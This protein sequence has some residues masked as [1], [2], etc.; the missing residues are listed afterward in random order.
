MKKLFPTLLLSLFCIHLIAQKNSTEKA[1]P[2]VEEGKTMYRSE[3]ASWYGTDYFLANY[4]DKSNIGGYFSYV[5]GEFS[6]CVFFSKEE[7]PKVIG[8][9]TFDSTYSLKDTEKDL[10]ERSL[11]DLEKNLYEIRRATLQKINSDTTFKQYENTSL[12]LIPMIYKRERKVYVLTGPAKAGVVIFG[13]DYL[14]TFNNEN[15]L[16]ESKPLHKNIL[17]IYY[18]DSAK[19]GEDIK[20]TM[21]THSPETGDFITATDIYTLMLYSK[22]AEWEKHYVVSKKYMSFWDCQNNSLF[23]LPKKAFDKMQRKSKKKKK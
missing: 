10:S 17:P 3:M 8:T 13:N 14:L 23:V 1:N 6:K 11:S 18:G 16:V 12:N 5:D 4:K 7:S 21:H 2:I 22:Y 9:I 20:E 19:E 15:E